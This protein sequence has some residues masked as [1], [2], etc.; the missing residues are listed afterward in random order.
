MQYKTLKKTMLGIFAAGLFLS[1][2]VCEGCA[3]SY[4]GKAL[5]NTKT[6]QSLQ[7]APEMPK[8][9]IDNLIEKD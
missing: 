6:E 7:R 2:Y 4:T 8:H 9:T 3:N 5:A 1:P